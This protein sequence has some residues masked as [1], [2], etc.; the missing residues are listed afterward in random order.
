MRDY[1][2]KL[3]PFHTLDTLSC[4]IRK[5]I[6]DHMYF[7]YCGL[8]QPEDEENLINAGMENTQ[9]ELW[10]IGEDGAEY[11]LCCGVAK[12]LQIHREGDLCKLTVEAVSGSYYED[13]VR[14]VRVFQ[15]ASSTYDAVL[16]HNEA[17]YQFARRM[18]S[19]FNSEVVP[20]YRTKG[21]HYYFGF[22]DGKQNIELSQSTYTIRKDAEDYL[23]KTKNQVL[24]LI[25][26]DAL[27]LEVE[28]RDVYEIG[29]SFPLRGQTY[30]IY[31]IESSGRTIP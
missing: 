5:C 10:M 28:S 25:E 18:A 9:V 12:N 21:V 20:A 17:P 27:C 30:Y 1:S 11:V 16:S 22:P 4:H 8:I 19:H 24:S 31:E 26:A 15:D 23:T 29:D 7:E 6:N 14:H 13:L 2:L 3:V